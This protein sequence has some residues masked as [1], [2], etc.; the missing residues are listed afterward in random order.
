MIVYYIVLKKIVMTNIPSHGQHW[1]FVSHG[2]QF[3]IA[4]GN[5]ALRSQPTD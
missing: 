2:A 4:F 3:D 5:Y 1:T